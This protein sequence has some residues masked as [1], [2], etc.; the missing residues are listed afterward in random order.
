MQISTLP[1]SLITNE[2]CPALKGCDTYSKFNNM[3]NAGAGQ[4]SLV[5]NE[6]GNVDICMD[7]L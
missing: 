5:I 1:F 3:G 4:T 7:W 2:V 6:N